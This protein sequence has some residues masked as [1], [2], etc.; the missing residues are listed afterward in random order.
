MKTRTAA[1]FILAL[2]LLATGLG[3]YLYPDL[4][5]QFASHWNARGE[6]DG[7]MS[8][9]WGVALVPGILVVVSLFFFAIPRIDPLRKNITRF[10]TQYNALIVLLGLFLFYVYAL[11]LIWN[12]GLRFHIGTALIPA[13][14]LL[15]FYIG[16]LLRHAKR[17][18]FIGIR[19]PWTLSSDIVWEK[20]HRLGSVLFQMSGVIAFAGILI[21]AYAMYIAVIP[22]AV[23]ALVLVVYSYISYE[24]LPR[25]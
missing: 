19:T 13:L 18:W 2:F 1:I 22:I 6:V 15:F 5:E 11:T 3:V 8:K 16:I 7:Y 10:R 21:P 4:P 25:G 9:F 17:N 12:L 20:T 14:G 24:R 23:S